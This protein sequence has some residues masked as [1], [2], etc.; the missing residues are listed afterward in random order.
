M[1]PHR[2]RHGSTSP[3]LA[4][5]LC[6]QCGAAGRGG[7]CKAHDPARASKDHAHAQR[8]AGYRAKV[9]KPTGGPA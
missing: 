5:R 2:H 4:A 9:T 6:Q 7:W 3:K 8:A 1:P